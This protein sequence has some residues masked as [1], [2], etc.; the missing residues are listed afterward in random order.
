MGNIAGVGLA[1]HTGGPGVVFWLWV[2][3]IIGM[4]TKFFTCTLATM[5]RG[6]DDS[7]EIQGGPMYFIEIGLGKK[8]KS[9]ALFFSIAG[10][11]GCVTFF[12]ANQLTQLIRDFIYQPLDIFQ[13]SEIIV[14]SFTGFFPFCFRLLAACTSIPPEPQQGS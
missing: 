11:F 6:K 13:G 2:S 5:Y 12:Q 14:N 1:I 4:G 8:Y 3:A 7:G 9:L 10:M